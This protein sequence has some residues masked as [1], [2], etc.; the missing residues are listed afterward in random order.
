MSVRYQCIAVKDSAV[1][2]YPPSLLLQC[3][4]G[5][6]VTRSRRCEVSQKLM[7][8]GLLRYDDGI[9]VG[10]A[11]RQR[12][13]FALCHLTLGTDTCAGSPKAKPSP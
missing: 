7:V 1:L 9:E 5:R 10:E 2:R 3:C 12:V 11:V 6:F 8:P 4:F 13:L